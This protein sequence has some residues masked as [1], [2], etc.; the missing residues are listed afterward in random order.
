M[1][2]QTA[3]ERYLPPIEDELR[4]CLAMPAEGVPAFY[5]MLHYHL[6]WTDANFQAAQARTGKRIRPMFTLLTCQAAGGEPAT[7]LPAAAAV[8]IIHNFSLIHDD[9]EDASETRRGRRT[10]WALWGQPQAINAG[11]GMFALAFLA[12][13]RLE[14]RGVP[15]E[16]VALTLRIL[17]E[18]C[19][20]LC[21]GQHLDMAFETSPT[22]EADSY[23]RMIGG[24]TAALLGCAAQLG[25]VVAGVE[26]STAARYRQMGERLGLAFQIQDDVL[27]IWGDESATGKPVADDIRSR[28]KT[29]P[30]IYGLGQRD[31]QG[32]RLR[33]LY[34]QP[35]LTEVEVEEVASL[36]AAVG[37]RDHADR[38]ARAYLEQALNELEAA[39]PRPDAAE[40][41]RELALAMVQRAA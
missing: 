34:A 5:G 30:V 24:K 40:A 17:A 21:Q 10:V 28:K 4:T 3:L 37:A 33:T 7:S 23:L 11:D 35:A 25:A 9:I 32:A 16:R 2:L 8:E 13:T 1:N 19:I 29:L 6:G 31:E 27:G 41:L 14:E 38:M 39:Q 26:P 18:T 36:L 20:A 12:L 22:V 15:A